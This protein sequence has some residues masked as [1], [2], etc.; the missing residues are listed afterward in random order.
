MINIKAKS[1]GKSIIKL[2]KDEFID[3]NALYTQ[4]KFSD[5]VAEVNNISGF[6]KNKIE[7]P[8]E[9]I[10]KAEPKKII[11]EQVEYLKNQK[12][13]KLNDKK[14]LKVEK[15]VE[16]EFKVDSSTSDRLDH[17]IYKYEL[18]VTKEKNHANSLFDDIVNRTQ[19]YIK[20]FN[21]MASNSIF[22]NLVGLVAR[23]IAPPPTENEILMIKDRIKRLDPKL[24]TD[25][26]VISQIVQS[27]ELLAYL[28]SLYDHVKNNVQTNKDLEYI[29]NI[30]KSVTDYITVNS[31]KFS[32]MSSPWLMEAYEK[33]K[34]VV[35]SSPIF[36]PNTATPAPITTAPTTF[37]FQSDSTASPTERHTEAP[38]QTQTTPAPITTQAPIT[39]PMPQYNPEDMTPTRPPLVGNMGTIYDAYVDAFRTREKLETFYNNLLGVGLSRSFMQIKQYIDRYPLTSEQM[40]TTPTATLTTNLINALIY[41]GM[42]PV[43]VIDELQMRATQINNDPSFFFQPVRTSQPVTPTPTQD[44][45]QPQTPAPSVSGMQTPTTTTAQQRHQLGTATPPASSVVGMQPHEITRDLEYIRNKFNEAFTTN[46]ETMKILYFQILD[47]SDTIL[48]KY[49]T[50]YNTLF[51]LD[52]LYDIPAELAPAKLY[53]INLFNALNNL[54]YP[55]LN[56]FKQMIRAKADQI[57]NSPNYNVSGALDI[58]PIEGFTPI[59]YIGITPQPQPTTITKPY[60]VKPAVYIPSIKAPQYVE[61]PTALNLSSSVGPVPI[62][63]NQIVAN[64]MNTKK[65]SMNKLKEFIKKKENV[66]LDITEKEAIKITAKILQN[67]ETVEEVEKNTYSFF[68]SIIDAL[69][70]SPSLSVGIISTILKY[71]YSTRNI[72]K[73]SDIP[74]EIIK[75]INFDLKVLPK[76]LITLIYDFGLRVCKGNFKQAFDVAKIIYD[77]VKS[78]TVEIAKDKLKN[79]NKD[80]NQA[81]EEGMQIGRAEG[82]AQEQTESIRRNVELEKK[83]IEDQT[84]F[85]NDTV[86]PEFEEIKNSINVDLIRSSFEEY[87]KFYIQIQKFTN[88]ITLWLRNIGAGNQIIITPLSKLGDALMKEEKLLRNFNSKDFKTIWER[89]DKIYRLSWDV[90]DNNNYQSELEKFSKELSDFIKPII[91]KLRYNR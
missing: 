64:K 75:N 44:Y 49:I 3:T 24:I 2:K 91:D 37:N 76:A 26:F 77:S 57:I 53:I 89:L 43:W 40:R 65:Q 38:T 39:E 63:K 81:M 4:N 80:I 34:G 83:I 27:P 36:A 9:F 52:K 33:I 46:I 29:S 10:M 28:K 47:K 5:G 30:V 17:E 61:Q 19:Q 67:S 35:F 55:V 69:L 82:Q 22:Q 58:T 12:P 6:P 84:K 48:N 60:D 54:N 31:D 8:E 50:L 90:S 41:I 1:K 70:Y 88:K 66:P 62:N 21:G 20:L 11:N 72:K 56:D 51:R 85:L 13:I 73:P 15:R 59:N 87:K 42:M 23:T 25:V 7:L 86:K 79:I 78:E 71:L 45:N 74:R 14:A 16:K 68:S 18:Q 32:M